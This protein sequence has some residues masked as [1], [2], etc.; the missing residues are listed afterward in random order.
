MS[1]PVVVLLYV[2][3]DRPDRIGNALA[4]GADGIIVDLEDAVAP[5]A[6]DAARGVLATLPDLVRSAF[7]ALPFPELVEGSDT[8]AGPP[9]PELVEGS[10]TNSEAGAPF[11][12]LGEG[13]ETT[14][15]TGERRLRQAQPTGSVAEQAG[16]RPFPELV[17]G[18]ETDADARRLRQ[19]QPTG[20]AAEQAGLRPFPE[21]AGL[22]PFPELV[23]GS[24]IQTNSEAGP[25]FPELV[26]GSETTTGTGERRLRQAQPTGSAAEQAGLRPFPELVEGPDTE[27]NSEAGPPFPE[28]VEGSETTTGT[29]ERRL[30]QA[31]PTGSVAEQAGL[32][33]FPELV[34]G[35]E[36]TTGTGE[37][38]LRQA[39]PTG[40]VAEQ[41]GLRPFPELVEGSETDADAR[42]LRQAQPARLPAPATAALP[43]V[44]VRIN[45][46]GTPWHDAD[47]EALAA[48]PTW[49][50]A[51]IPKAERVEDVE[52]LARR[53][54]GRDLH[55]LIESPLGVERAFDLASCPQVASLGLG[56]ADLKADLGVTADGLDWVRGRIVNAARAAGLSSPLMSA[57]THVTDLEGLAA[58]CR[59]GRARGFLGRSA[60]HPKQ[61]ATIRDS[62]RPTAEEVARAR[63]VLDR[64][65]GSVAAGVGALQLADG[66]FLDLAMVESARRTIA[67]ATD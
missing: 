56:E 8:E 14:T 10:E 45:A 24:E 31:Q 65:E 26:E 17:E 37:R 40:S 55:L 3:A 66:T 22:R 13:S 43:V 7:P 28:L 47:V 20:S 39:Q 63:T 16:L 23:E 41:A 1:K 50:G 21:Q 19:A 25:P 33:P 46:V 36:T 62:F 18:S 44:Q 15:G 12:E 30:R 11:P 61:I 34:E 9:F 48:L 35:S 54:P 2:P 57:F 5:S 4:S 6:K 27:T 58:S 60:I 59:D 51:R 38:R 64:I 29:G 32:R 42:R 52:A 49:V 67:L 53:L